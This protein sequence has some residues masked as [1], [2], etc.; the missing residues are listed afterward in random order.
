MIQSLGQGAQGTVYEVRALGD[1]YALKVYNQLDSNSV[2]AQR[3]ARK[4]GNI[5]SKPKTGALSRAWMV[6]NG[7]DNEGNP[8]MLYRLFKHRTFEDYYQGYSPPK[9]LKNR[10]RIAIGL[11]AGLVEI[12]SNSIIHSDLAPL[13]ILY[14]NVGRVAIID[15]DGSGYSPERKKKLQPIVQGHIQFPDWPIPPEVVN[16]EITFS[17]DIWWLASL[18]MKALTGYSPFFFLS[19]ADHKSILELLE[20]QENGLGIWPPEFEVVSK[21]SKVQPNLNKSILDKVRQVMNHTIATATIGQVFMNYE[22]QEKRPTAKQVW[23]SF[24]SRCFR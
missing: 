15:F 20:I 22:D 5:I 13:N 2:Q 12:H 10:E 9:R 21:H 8:I 6:D 1:T 4:I 16:N 17:S 23:S 7:S 11:S 3:R 19:V 24:R 18:I 14:S